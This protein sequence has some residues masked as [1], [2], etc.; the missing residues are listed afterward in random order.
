MSGKQGKG[1]RCFLC[2]APLAAT[3]LD[4]VLVHPTSEKCTVQ[5][6][7]LTGISVDDQYELL[8]GQ[9]YLRDD[10]E[11]Q[12]DPDVI[13]AF[14]QWTPT[15][16]ATEAMFDAHKVPRLGGASGDKGWSSF[17]TYQ[18]CPYLW[19]RTYIEH[20]KRDPEDL[21]VGEAPG[22]AVGGLVHTFLAIHYIRPIERRYPLTPESAKDWLLKNGV[23]PEFLDEAWR[24][25]SAYRLFY[26]HEQIRPLAVEHHVVDPRTGE[27]TR[28]D[29]VCE[30]LAQE[31]RIPGTYIMDHKTA[32]RFDA[33][34]LEGWS[35]DGTVIQQAM[36][37]E[38]LG[39]KH[40]FGELKGVIVNLIG[41]QK[42]PDMHRTWVAPHRWQIEQQEADLRIWD[43]RIRLALA[44]G[45]FPRARSGCI[46]RYG[47]C[48]QFEH[49]ATGE[50]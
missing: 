38:R 49:C 40:K 22:I 18:R 16:K 45:V 26:K 15:D 31:G 39:L 19:R 8:A 36:L 46:N 13:V 41:K 30:V 11:A 12:P 50:G 37:W 47:F 21:L 42:V 14:E 33:P 32:Q 20:I 29:L 25:F 17:Q 5:L 35:N 10:G 44:T 27:S 2:Q 1:P 28:Y 24:L 4:G 3:T 48:S 34:T 9:I 23:N 7:E 6:T 43:A